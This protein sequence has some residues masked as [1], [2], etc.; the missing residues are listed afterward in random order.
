MSVR[1]SMQLTDNCGAKII[2]RF[3]RERGITRVFSL[4]G[5]HIMPIWMSVDHEGI[6][7]IDVRDERAAI[8]MAQAHAE[9]TG[10]LGVA[11]VTAGPGLTNAITGIANAHVSRAPILVISGTPPIP[12]MGRGALQDL[13]HVR[14]VRS[15]TRYA[16][17]VFDSAMIPQFLDDA[18]SSALGDGSEPGPAYIEFPTDVVRTQVPLPVQMQ[19]YFRPRSKRMFQPQQKDIAAAVD[20]LW[21]ARRPVFISGRGARDAAKELL[22]LLE[23]LDAVHLDT[24]ESRGVVPDNHSS[25][26]ASMRGAVMSSADVIVTVGR[27]LDFQL[28][29]GSP[30]IFKDAHFLRISDC[31]P[32][33]RDN[34]RGDVELFGTISES[35]NAVVQHAGDRKPSV[36]QEWIGLIKSK[37]REKAGAFAQSIASAPNGA[38][39]AIH[40][41]R[42]LSEVQSHIDRQS[43]VVIDGGDVLSFARVG[44]SAP[45]V[46][47]P[48]PFGC[49]GVGVPY[50]I[51]ASLARPDDTVFVVTGDGSFGFNAI[52]VDTAVRHNAKVVI[53]VANNSAWQIEVDDQR[54]TYGRIIGTKLQNADYAAMARAFGMHA[55]RVTRVDELTGSLTRAL[56]NRPALVDVVV[57]TDAESSDSKSGLAWVPNLQPLAAWDDAEF[58]W[59]HPV[60]R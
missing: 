37:H 54:K 28:A 13:D 12:Q 9:V 3:L 21:K 8:H 46:L 56:A 2:A 26:V 41:N 10:E 1:S 22:A 7:I 11:L 57:T 5:G 38:D 20:M 48:G 17:T 27:R 42:L 45:I 59:R 23:R 25:M 58:R 30:A 31:A 32:E 35:L 33:L 24:G 39:G 53:I 60:R 55:E 36:D 52:E 40:P 4:C 44:I 15:I 14:L 47:D 51:A 43:I 19:E 16:R 29:F 18:V 50:G 49:I 34:R 6:Q